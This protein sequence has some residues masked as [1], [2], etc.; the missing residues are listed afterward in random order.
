[1]RDLNNN[2]VYPDHWAG[3]VHADGRIIGGAFWDLREAVGAAIADSLLHYAKYSLAEQW[4]DYFLDVLILDD[5]DADLSNGGPHHPEIYE[6]FGIHG[7]GPGVEPDLE[8]ALSDIVEDG[9][10]GSVGNGNGFFEPDEILS[11]SFSVSDLRWLYPPAAEDVTVAVS[12]DNPDLTFEPTGFLLGSIPAGMTVEAPENLLITVSPE[13]ELAFA[14]IIFEISANGGAYQVTDSLE[15]V[16]GHPTLLLVDDDGGDHYQQ[17]FD[18]SLR[19]TDQIY[20][21]YDISGSGEIGLDLLME[22][23]VAIWLTGNE[24]SNTLTAEDQNNLAQY[25]DSGRNL[26]ITGQD[27]VEDIGSTAFFS[28]YLGALPVAGQVSGYFS[29]EGVEGDPVSGGQWVMIIGA[30]AGANQTSPGAI[31]ALPGAEAIFHYTYDPD[32]RAGAVRYDSGIFKTVTFSF[33]AEAIS[34][35]AE[36]TPL[37][38]VL[39]SI[40]AWF[41]SST[42]PPV[43]EL[44]VE[45]TYVSGSPIPAT[46]GD[47]Y[48]GIWAENQAPVP[49]SWDGWIDMVYENSDTTL[50]LLRSIMNFLPGWQISRPDV[51][52]PVPSNWPGGNYELVAH[53]GNQST[54]WVWYQDSFSWLKEGAVDLDF[55]F[56]AHLPTAGFPDPFGEIISNEAEAVMPTEYAIL[57]AYPNPFNPVTTIS[58]QLPKASVVELSVYDISG[59]QV[60][61]LVNGWRDA[62]VHNIIFDASNL[63]SGLYFYRIEAGSY[64]D[65]KKM[66]LIK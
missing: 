26:F 29:L 4:E 48:Y 14:Q 36:S 63:A 37:E 38:D 35:L 60:S 49:L 28:D 13:A 52:Y 18:T 27:L 56:E 24:S 51:F 17:F 43:P 39:G 59:R 6:S 54:L 20:S 65:V 46:G 31:A 64:S 21:T 32:L 44:P 5:D 12:S 34:G 3:Q 45:V 66:V 15:I 25:L 40:L 16:V 53:S 62:G 61:E 55:D 30:G 7:I 22:F 42:P 19:V 9:T 58:Y 1:M 8:I 10:N 50:I 2:L 11:M 23:E 47:L 57:D 41:D 33:G